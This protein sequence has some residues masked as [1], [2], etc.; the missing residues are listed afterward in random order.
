L[1][2]KYVQLHDAYLSVSESLKHAGYAVDAK[3][4]IKWV[5][6]EWLTKDN[7]VQELGEVDG[8]LVPGGFGGRGIE[9]KILAAQYA[10]ENKIPYFGICLG[11]QISMIEF[12]RNVCGLTDANSSEW[13]EAT[14]HPI[15]HLMPDQNGVENMGGTLRLGN[16]PCALTEGTKTQE[17]YNTDLIQERHRHRYE[18][19]NDY[20]AIMSEKG[21]IFSGLSPDEYLV[22][23]TELKDHPWYV[24]CQFHPEFKSRPNR[25]HPLFFGFVQAS[26]KNARKGVK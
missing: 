21:V 16:W 3:V 6:S 18:F 24:G 11:M 17:V 25:P 9:G 19:N 22:E 7:L 20:R 15:I 5:N 8:I 4:E 23:I 1:V 14:T 10:R 13:D 12:A 2:G 26:F